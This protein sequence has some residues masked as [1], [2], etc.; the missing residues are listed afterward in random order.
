MAHT[1][2]PLSLGQLL[3][4]TFNLYRR[5]FLLFVGISAVPNLVLLLVQLGLDM[6]ALGSND[7]TAVAL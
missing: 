2:R 5:N 3:D 4:E 7:G 6:A 1:L